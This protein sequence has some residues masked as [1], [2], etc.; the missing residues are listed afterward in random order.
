MFRTLNKFHSLC[1]YCS[2]DKPILNA[3][4]I[5]D[6]AWPVDTIS[7]RS[8]HVFSFIAFYINANNKES[9]TQGKRIECHKHWRVHILS[10]SHLF[11]VSWS[12]HWHVDEVIFWIEAV[13]KVKI[14]HLTSPFKATEIELW[15]SHNNTF[16]FTEMQRISP[17]NVIWCFNGSHFKS[18]HF[19]HNLCSFWNSY[20]VVLSNVVS[21]SLFFLQL[22][23]IPLR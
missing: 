4:I 15:F 3:F 20:I 22:F 23:I 7:C 14:L 16:R 8:M 13:Y 10:L 17:L 19:E 5:R 12:I 6:C 1:L 11:N 21:R 9:R 18:Q 2:T